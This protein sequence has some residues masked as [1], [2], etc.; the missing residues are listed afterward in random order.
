MEESR[1]SFKILKGSPTGKR[2][3]GRPRRI[4]EDNIMMDLKEMGINRKN[5][6][7]SVQGRDYRRAPEKAALDFRFL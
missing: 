4:C 2:P 7:D 1:S 6:V 3:L 5:W